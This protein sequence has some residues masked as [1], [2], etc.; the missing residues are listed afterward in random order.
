MIFPVQALTLPRD[1][2]E[3]HTGVASCASTQCH[4]AA[5]KFKDSTILN[6]EYRRWTKDD[7]HAKAYASLRSK[8]AQDMAQKLGLPN[9]YE[10]QICLDCHAD[11]VPV[12]RRGE[13]FQLSDGVGCEACHGGSE[14][15]LKSHTEKNTK[16]DDNVAKGMYPT[17]QPVA[18][19]KMCLSC[20]FGNAKQF[21]THRIMGA[22]HPR[23]R[24]ELDT[25]SN[26]QQ[27]Y[28][29]DDDY[30]QR[31]TL[32][33]GPK[34]WALGM[35]QA[36]RENM[37]AIN[38]LLFR[39]GGLFPE[40]ALFD[41]HACHHAMNDKRSGKRTASGNLAPGALR[42]NDSSLVMLYL[43]A[44]Q[45]SAPQAEKLLAAI[46]QWHEA[47]S[48][49]RD[50][51]IDKSK[52]IDAIAAELE[53]TFSAFEFSAAANGALL[54][55]VVE[56]GASNEFRDY[57]AAEQAY[58]G[59]ALLAF[60]LKKDAALGPDLDALFNLLKDDSRYK[61]VDFSQALARLKTRWS[62]VK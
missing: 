44:T 54:N 6:D 2:P 49:S 55:R 47:S 61:S 7:P 58:M 19:A 43:I 38:G 51:V 20:H 16:H 21:A 56:F 53:K 18:R 59:I 41:C 37:A 13:K 42:L 48:R 33:T 5:K 4:G 17:E 29:F 62:G 39:D 14:K 46:R 35:V 52:E 23:L 26:L 24:Y 57:V 32:V 31:K 45:V 27:H 22:G 50:A 15:W 1:A 36:V 8:D 60:A 12:D 34:L 9:A 10:A 40:I 30:R 28:E 25:F 3:K 11:N